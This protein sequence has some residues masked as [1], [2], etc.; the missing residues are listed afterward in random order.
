MRPLLFILAMLV[1]MLYLA[2][3]AKA[4]DCVSPD[5]TLTELDKYTKNHNVQAQAY[6]WQ[7]P[8]PPVQLMIVWFSNMPA[9]VIVSAFK[10]NCLVVPPSGNPAQAVPLDADVQQ[11]VSGSKLI[12]DNGVKVSPFASY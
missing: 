1:S 4:Q 9:V 7:S 2:W 12:Y 5:M 3:P 11:A 10:D 8:H 6:M